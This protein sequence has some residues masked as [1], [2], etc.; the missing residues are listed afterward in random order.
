M[1]HVKRF[2][3]FVATI[4]MVMCAIIGIITLKP[5][6]AYAADSTSVEK[7]EKFSGELVNDH[8]P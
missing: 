4:C 8:T 3:V 2:S 6:T 5:Q 7:I 1:L